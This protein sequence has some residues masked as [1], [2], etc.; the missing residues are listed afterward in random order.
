MVCCKCVNN[1]T[2]LD[3]HAKTN[4]VSPLARLNYAISLY[5]HSH[6]VESRAQYDQFCLTVDDPAVHPQYKEDVSSDQAKA[7]AKMLGEALGVDQL[8]DIERM[9]KEQDGELPLF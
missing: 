1:H 3:L 5:R 4:S 9:V 6:L 8:S 7:A 2:L